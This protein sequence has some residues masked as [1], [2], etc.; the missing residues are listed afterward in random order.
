V[1]LDSEAGLALSLR[2]TFDTP[3]NEGMPPEYRQEVPDQWHFTAATER[4]TAATRIAA[5]MVVRAKGETFTTEWK[6]RP[7]WSGVAM[8][9]EAGSGEVWA[10]YAGGAT[11][12][13]G[14]WRPLT[15]PPERLAK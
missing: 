6:Q 14:I 5:A 7:G 4:R 12:L 11:Q 2:H 3:F 13:E 8:E 15:G 10:R 9:S 1:K